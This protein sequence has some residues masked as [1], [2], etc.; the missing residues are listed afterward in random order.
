M[1]HLISE[2]YLYR[3]NIDEY[4]GALATE[5]NKAGYLEKV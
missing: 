3:E 5:I 4:F 2:E 1:A